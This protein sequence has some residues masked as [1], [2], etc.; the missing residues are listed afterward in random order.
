MSRKL[1]NVVLAVA[2]LAGLFMVKPAA[3]Q[4]QVD[5]GPVGGPVVEDGAYQRP[6]AVKPIDQPNPK[7]YLRNMNRMQLLKQGNTLAADKLALQGTDRVLVLLVEFTGTDVFTWT[8]NISPAL[9]SHWDPLG[10]ADPSEDTGTL[11]DCSNIITQTQVFTYTGPLHNQ[12]DRPLSL[13][14]RSGDSIWTEDFSP[15]WF[16]SFMFKEGVVISYTRQDGSSV[17]E[18]FT[19]KSVNQYYEDLSN[20]IYHIKGDVIGWLPLNHSTYYYDADECPGARS[21][22]ARP[23]RGGMI[24]GAGTPQQMVRD[25]LDAVNVKIEAGELPNFKWTDYDQD[26]DG[27]IDRLWVVHAGLG[28]EDSTTLLNRAEYGEGAAWSHSSAIKAYEVDP[29]NKISASAYIMMPEN[30]GIGVFAHEYSHNLGSIDLYA[31][32]GG[33]TSAGFWTLMADDWV[34][35]PI[36]YEPPAMDPMHLNW[37]GWLKPYVITDTSK[38]YE[39]NLGQASYFP[40]SNPDLYRAAKIELPDG[41]APLPVPVWGGSYYWWGGKGD[42]MNSKMTLKNPIAVPAAP[43]TTTLSFDA[44]YGIETEWDFLWIQ[45]SADNGATWDTLTNANTICEHSASWIGE[46]NGFPADICA[47]GIGGLTDYNPSFPDPDTQEFDLSAYAGKNVLLRF[48]YMTDWGSTYEGPFI[49]NVKVASGATTLLSD[50]A[51]ANGDNWTYA[52]NWV[53]SD[54]MKTFKHAFYFQWRNT[55]DNGGYDS[56]LGDLRWRYGKADTGM[57]VWYENENYTDNEVASYLTDFPSFGTKGRM[58][59]VDSHPEPYRDPAV[60]AEGYP[61]MAANID[62]RSQ[63]RNAPFTLAPIQ[64]WQV[65]AGQA[66]TDTLFP[67]EPAQ[68][69][70]HDSINYYP[71]AELVRR[72]PYPSQATPVWLAKQWDGSVVGPATSA[73]GMK[74][75]GLLATTGFRYDCSVNAAGLLACYW[76]AGGVGQAGTASGNPAEVDAQYGWHAEVVSEATDHTWA[77]VRIWNSM[78]AVDA[79]FTTAKSQ[80]MVGDTVTYTL[81]MQ[82]VGSAI[83]DPFYVCVPVDTN[84]V[85]YVTG[86]AAGATPV[87]GCSQSLK[88]GDSL[89]ADAKVG[90]LMWKID[91]MTHMQSQNL[92]FAVKVIASAG[93]YIPSLTSLFTDFPISVISAPVDFGSKIYLPAVQK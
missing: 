15:E 33:E 30:G 1:F 72:S 38:T 29:V 22:S 21:T 43:A 36:G 68:S 35:S 77:K 12:I 27:I 76:F 26:G 53:R 71:G 55:N 66:V 2:L 41:K 61:N 62:P 89:A 65:E 39:V 24:P 84:L 3:A 87:S 5:G 13:T 17:F 70:F 86:S 46:D 82:N 57:V 90:G 44:A 47:A 7:D 85:E 48:W 42:E 67:S 45:A 49:D 50:D 54:G 69:V 52:P 32:N 34:G 88:P 56:A 19:G 81:N 16:D 8:A 79:R 80:V 78:E 51:E 73:Y 83:S 31:Y 20:G 74:A 9:S 93:K 59:V 4:Q 75:P 6:A 64:P 25:A 40:A 58:L 14:D 28:E 11:G 37:W 10:I 60:I 91:P 18:D 23:Q 92:V 63:T